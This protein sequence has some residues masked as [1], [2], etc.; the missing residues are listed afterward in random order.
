[1]IVNNDGFLRNTQAHS[2]CRH[3][4]LPGKSV[5]LMASSG[6]RGQTESCQANIRTMVG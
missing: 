2:A 4:T 1:M 6:D 5:P 3:L